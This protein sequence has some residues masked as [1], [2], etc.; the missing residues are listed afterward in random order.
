[1]LDLLKVAGQMQGMSEQL[2]KEA[3]ML[4]G[5]LNLAEE[6]FNG[7][8]ANQALHT[9]QREDWHSSLAFACAEPVE[10]LSQ[11]YAIAPITTPHTVLATDGSQISPSRHEIAYCYLLN[12]GRVALHYGSKVYPLLDSIPEVHYKP[13]DLYGARQWGIQTEEWMGLKRM[14][15]EAIALAELADPHIHYPLFTSIP[16]LALQDGSL[17]HWNLEMLPAEA[18][19]QILPDV[20]AAWDK[21]RAARVPLAGYISSPRTVEAVNFLRLQACPFPAPDCSKH[22]TNKILDSVPCSKVQPLR[23]ATLW[24]RLLQPGEC[25]PLWRSHARILQEYGEHWIYFCYLHVG[26]EVAR[27]EM[28]AWTAL[29]GELRSQVLSII[30]A[31]V[32]KGYGYPIALAEAH[33]QAVVTGG[34]RHRF[35]T[36]LEQEMIRSG[37]RNVGISYKEARKR[38]SIA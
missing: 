21:L 20:L 35:F 7:A 24:H 17:V 34:D 36:I 30:L 33:N 32:Q 2:Q 22:C 8:I 13:E 9:R 6:L 14:V 37:I 10:L 27:V 3:R 18:R 31:Q 16:S 15:L 1:M 4:A 23:D 19:A 25:S 26:A 5:K 28:P 12:V 29:D 11:R 38:G